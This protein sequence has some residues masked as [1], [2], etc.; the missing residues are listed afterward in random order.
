MQKECLLHSRT[1]EILTNMRYLYSDLCLFVL[2]AYCRALDKRD[3]LLII[4]D[5][6]CLFCIKNVVTAHV[7]RFIETVHMRGHY[8][9]FK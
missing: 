4:G 1:V 5:I 7:N 6:F 9:G 3:Y 2:V 8:V